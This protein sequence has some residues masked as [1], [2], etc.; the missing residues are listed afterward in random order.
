MGLSFALWQL[1]LVY[2][3]GFLLS[4]AFPG[5][6]WRLAGISTVVGMAAAAAGIVLMA[7][8]T[9]PASS[10]LPA[11]LIAVVAW[12]IIRFSRDYLRGEA[13]QPRYVAA[14]LFT[15]T[16]VLTVVVADHLGLLLAAWAAT[17]LGLHRL[18]VFY[19]ERVPAQ[20]AAHKKFIASRFA[21]LCLL[22]AVLLIFHTL[23]TFS[24]TTATALL[25]DMPDLPSALNLAAVLIAVAVLLKSA[26][27]P[28]HGWLMQVMEAPTP[29]SA[30]LHA[31]IVNLGGVVVIRLAALFSASATAQTLLVVFGS[32]TALLAG[33]AMLTRISIKVRLAWSTCAQM[34][35][36]LM[37]CGLGLYDLA[38]LHLIA[39]SLY[40]AHAF[41]SAGGT[42]HRA[43]TEDLLPVAGG[44]SNWWHSL[45]GA[46]LAIPAVQG[47]V[48]VYGSLPM[49][50]PVNP[51]ASLILALGVAPLL[52]GICYI[53]SG[54]AIA[55]VLRAGGVV[56]LYL[57]WHT[58]FASLVPVHHSPITGLVVL[59][60]LVFAGFYL[61]QVWIASRPRGRLADRLFAVAFA[62]FYLDEKVT[63]LTFRLWPIA[64]HRPPSAASEPTRATSQ[65][66]A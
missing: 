20:V 12:V 23:D 18:L 10:A 57:A 1:P 48:L 28:L 24:I 47:A 25:R 46:A 62:G 7:Q 29:V 41:L 36:M 60:S 50:T 49:A 6:A 38:M 9:A 13:R 53:R 30:F 58:L 52:A 40:K 64:L 8:G 56:G 11:L 15:L 54:L 22:V 33:I 17:S 42:V 19:P 61:A 59:A 51:A 43:R 37:E 27:L 2:L 63:R 35:F 5:R 34:G 14:L 55:A 21:E 32:L 16:A 45:V 4:C 31:G 39:H 26:Q 66:V 65:G 3:T 44:P